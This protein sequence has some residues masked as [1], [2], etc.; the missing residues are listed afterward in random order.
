MKIYPECVVSYYRKNKNQSI[1]VLDVGNDKSSITITNEGKIFVYSTLFIDMSEV[2]SYSELTDNFL[3][4][5]NF[6]S[7]RNFGNK[8]D[9]I[10]VVGE[11]SED[12]Q[13]IKTLRENIDI[14]I[15][16]EYKNHYVEILGSFMEGKAIHNKSIDFKEA[17][18]DTLKN[19]EVDKIFILSIISVFLIASVGMGCYY[20]TEVYLNGMKNTVAPSLISEINKYSDVEE[21]IS[22]LNNE[23][24]NYQKKVD[25]INQIKNDE[26]NYILIIDGL[27]K[28]L[29]KNITVKFMYI[30]SEKISITLNI[31]NSTL[32]VARAVIALNNTKLFET[33]DISKVR[34][35]DT[36]NSISL[37]LKLQTSSARLQD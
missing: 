7:T 29:P 17:L 25:V 22:E 16:H 9:N 11:K 34:L 32:D 36:V 21:K 4:F 23:K 28:G 19:K 14:N 30:Q 5:L 33:V 3:Y 15:S 26:F 35:D 1:A 18:K 6:Y 12:T 8:V 2:G 27:K 10:Y 20:Y 37:D 13:L 31:N 24:Q